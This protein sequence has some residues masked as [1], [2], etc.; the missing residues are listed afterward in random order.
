MT[1]DIAQPDP[2]VV[3]DLLTREYELRRRREPTLSLT[4]FLARF[5]QLAEEL[6][7]RLQAMPAEPTVAVEKSAVADR[8]V[9]E[10]TSGSAADGQNGVAERRGIVRAHHTAASRQRQRFDDARE[11]NRRSQGV[12]IRRQRRRL[13]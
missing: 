13:L 6:E 10:P 12:R 5:P 9:A 11:D 4:V 2:G 7:R 3:L 8:T 1:R